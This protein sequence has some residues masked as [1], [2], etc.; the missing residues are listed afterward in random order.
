MIIGIGGV[1][2]A[3]KTTL[4]IQLKNRI[5][6]K[7]ICILNQDDFVKKNDLPRVKSHIDWEHPVS[8]DWV[9]LRKTITEKRKIYDILMV[10]GIFAY[11]DPKIVAWYDSCLFVHIDQKL[12][13]QR[14][15]NDLRW[16]KEPEWFIQHIWNSYKKYNQTFNTGK[17][18]LWIEGSSP[19]RFKS[20]LKFLGF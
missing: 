19:T 7:T 12:F 1:S 11:Y 5:K 9:R 10:E 14:K 20:L 16:G 8:I 15:R 13:L 4:A 3:G 18:M 2:R 6:G 17:A